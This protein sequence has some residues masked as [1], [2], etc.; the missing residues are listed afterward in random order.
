[1]KTK[2][3]VALASLWLNCYW[4]RLPPYHQGCSSALQLSQ[5][6]SLATVPHCMDSYV[7]VVLMISLFVLYNP[8]CRPYEQHQDS[9]CDYYLGK[10]PILCINYASIHLKC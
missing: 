2:Q 8:D 4:M 9:H 10:I 3:E 6:T 1:M 7:P 5:S